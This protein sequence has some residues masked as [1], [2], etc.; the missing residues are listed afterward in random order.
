MLHKR[1][2]AKGEP[3]FPDL[4]GKHVLITGG[5]NGIGAALCEAFAHQGCALTVLDKDVDR[6]KQVLLGCQTQAASTALYPVDLTDLV[7]LAEILARVRAERPVVDVLIPN[8]GYDPRYDGVNMTD[9]QWMDLFQLNVAHYFVACRELVP[10]MK[11][12]GQGASIIMTA[13]HTAWL[14]KPQLVAYNSTKAAIVGLTRS[15]AEAYGPDRI[16][17]NAVAPGWVMTDRQ[18][19]EWVTPEAITQTV[20]QEQAM[21]LEL[22]PKEMV[23]PYLFLASNSSMAMTRQIL[24]ADAGQSKH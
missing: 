19:E 23:G 8:A 5:S 3:T 18:L 13:S 16:R 10:A 14:A 1:T 2:D 24:V 17:V 9:Q 11:A 22:T 7:A 6:G 21:P 12:S 20:F 15:L 4:K